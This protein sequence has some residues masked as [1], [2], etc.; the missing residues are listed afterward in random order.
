MGDTAAG[1]QYSHSAT[2]SELSLWPTTQ[3]TAMFNPVSKAMDRTW[4]LVDTSRVCNH[5]AMMGNSN[6]LIFCCGFLHLC[7]GEIL[8][9]NFFP[10]NVF[11]LFLYFGNAGLK[12][13]IKR[14]SLC[15]YLLYKIVEN[16]YNF[17]L[18]CFVELTSEP[19]WAWCFP[20][21][22]DINYW[23]NFYYRYRP[24]LFPICTYIYVYILFM[25][26]F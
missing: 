3:L 10:Y 22:K 20:F 8:V 23:F 2:I 16:W 11:A 15:I 4:V 5:W 9:F 19:I 13:W 1:L 14:Y 18:K 6:L 7:S 25:F 17:F 26:I 24:I 21:W 12:E